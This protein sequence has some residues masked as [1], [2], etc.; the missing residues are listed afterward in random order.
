MFVTIDELSTI[1]W[2]VFIIVSTMVT[3]VGIYKIIRTL[4]EIKKYNS[5]IKTN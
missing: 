5:N 1:I 4:R 3:I 2:A